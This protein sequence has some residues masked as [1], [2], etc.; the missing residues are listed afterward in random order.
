MEE[1]IH[2]GR[3][4]PSCSRCPYVF[5]AN[6][7]AG[8]AA[9]VIGDQGRILLVRRAIEPF[10]GAWALPAGYQEVDEEPD[11]AAVREVQEE[12]GVE[13]RSLGLLDVLFVPDDP[14][15]PAN[16]LVYLCIPVGGALRPIPEVHDVDRAGWFDL[17]ALPEPIGFDNY[18]RI[19]ERLRDPSGYPASPWNRLA[20]LL[21]TGPSAQRGSTTEEDG[22]SKT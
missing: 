15:K 16:V 20:E 9:V 3:L 1:S 12:T 21:P 19:L 17:D 18:S 7:A 8:S 5:Y 11:A 4:R 2:E 10:R 22:Y 6:P 13:V 14:R